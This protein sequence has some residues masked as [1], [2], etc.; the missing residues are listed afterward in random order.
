MIDERVAAIFALMMYAHGLFTGWYLKRY[1][2]A[3]KDSSKVYTVCVKEGDAAAFFAFLTREDALA[4]HN[5]LVAQGYDSTV[6]ACDEGL[7]ISTG[8]ADLA[9]RLTI[10]LR[11][12]DPH[13]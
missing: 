10:A 3:V 8:P 2:N 11:H 4:Q 1:K 9:T 7:I 13:P 5:K 6:Y 12:G